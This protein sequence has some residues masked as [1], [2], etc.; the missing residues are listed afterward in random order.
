VREIFVSLLLFVVMLE[1]IDVDT[2]GCL[3]AGATT[4][5]KDWHSFTLV[6]DDEVDKVDIFQQLLVAERRKS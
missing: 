4:V 3:T 2:F 5:C 1:F 6:N